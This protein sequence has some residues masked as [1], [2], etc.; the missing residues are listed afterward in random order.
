MSTVSPPVGVP[1]AVVLMPSGN[2]QNYGFDNTL[3]F[4]DEENTFTYFQD[5]FLLDMIPA[6]GPTHG[7]TKIYITGFGFRQ[8]Q[9][10]NGTHKEQDLFVRFVDIF[11]N[12][13]GN[14]SSSIDLTSNDF[15]WFTPSAPAGTQ[16]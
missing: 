15:V 11:G 13:I 7:H 5:V 2:G 9:H 1:D 12:Q 6:S 10:N 3:H 14:S 4:R 8:F 16:A